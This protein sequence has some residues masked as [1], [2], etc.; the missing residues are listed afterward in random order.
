MALVKLD[1][2]HHAKHLL[3]YEYLTLTKIKHIYESSDA[4]K[5]EGYQK[6]NGPESV[7]ITTGRGTYL[8]AFKHGHRAETNNTLN[9][10]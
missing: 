1:T 4:Y 3:N 10:Q 2:R 6:I 5:C 8:K 7:H 9:L